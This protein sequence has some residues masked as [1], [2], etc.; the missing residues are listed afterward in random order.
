MGWACST[1]G[2]ER[3]VYRLLAGRPEAKRALGIPSRWC[4]NN[5]RTDL[6]EVG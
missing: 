2:E 1:N 5:I 6:G 3:N 4:L